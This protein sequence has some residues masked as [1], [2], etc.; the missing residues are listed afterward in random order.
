MRAIIPDL[1][2]I[3][4]VV[5]EHARED[6]KATDLVGQVERLPLIVLNIGVLNLV[7]R[8]LTAE[9][10]RVRFCGINSR[11]LPM[12]RRASRTLDDFGLWFFISAW[13][14]INSRTPLASLTAGLLLHRR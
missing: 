3:T 14:G 7:D 9:E 13:E 2:N 4:I 11:I 1:E 10:G 6:V 8:F 12:I 5:H